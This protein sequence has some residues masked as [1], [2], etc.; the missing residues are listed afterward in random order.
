MNGTWGTAAPAKTDDE[1]IAEWLEA[2][3]QLNKFKALEGELRKQVVERR[4]ASAPDSGT[5]NSD[6]A[7]GFKLKAV[8]KLNYNL[9]KA[10]EV[11]SA[12]TKIEQS[13]PEGA[14]IVSRLVKWKPELSVTEYKG[15]D[16]KFKK[17][18]DTVLTVSKG[19][20]SVELVTPKAAQ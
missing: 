10:E 17:I 12:L 15:L 16:A 7:N 4:F 19:S 6:L 1:L 5:V 8:F 14:F 3:N 2:Q 20:P 18:I 11:E 13:G 9:K